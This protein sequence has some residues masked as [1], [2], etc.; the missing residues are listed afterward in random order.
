VLGAGL[1]GAP[2]AAQG[3]QRILDGALFARGQNIATNGEFKTLPFKVYR[4]V[5]CLVAEGKLVV[6]LP[7]SAR[8]GEAQKISR[9]IAMQAV[10]WQLKILRRT[11]REAVMAV[12]TG[13]WW[14]RN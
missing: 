2:P 13:K 9:L 12:V 7:Q 11:C 14:K 6:H 5:L 1:E 8:S 10:F 3:Q 4:K